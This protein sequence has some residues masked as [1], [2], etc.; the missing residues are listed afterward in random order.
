MRPPRSAIEPLSEGVST[1]RRGETLMAS[2]RDTP[3]AGGAVPGTAASG[4]GVPGLVGVLGGALLLRQLVLR[5]LAR[6]LF[7]H[8]RP[9]VEQ[10]PAKQ[11]RH[12]Q[13]DGEQEV[14]LL[15]G[16]LRLH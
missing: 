3:A 1:A 9:G 11:D 6:L 15:I 2:S 12:R 16:V 10:L 5:A 4:A 13:H 7:L 8:L 14:S